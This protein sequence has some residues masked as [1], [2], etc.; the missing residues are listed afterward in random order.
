MINLLWSKV[1]FQE[2]E[3]MDFSKKVNSNR[4]RRVAA[5]LFLYLGTMRGCQK[6]S[7][8]KGPVGKVKL[9]V[10]LIACKKCGNDSRFAFLHKSKGE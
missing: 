10:K 4:K 1:K 7:F 8:L 9:R 5:A 6:E 3:K 2:R